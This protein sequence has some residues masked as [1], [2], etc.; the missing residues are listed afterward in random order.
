MLT[1]TNA[2]VAVVAVFATAMT[3][4]TFAKASV[5]I[6]GAILTPGRRTVC[7]ALRVM[8][9]GE[10][11]TFGKYHRV[12]SRDR[13]SPWRVSEIL[14][15]LL[16][17]TFGVSEMPL[18]L[19][20][21]ETLERR[22]GQAI[23]YKGVFR[24]GVRSTAKRVVKSLGIRWACMALL[25]KVPW[26]QREWALPF[27]IVPVLSPKTSERLHKRHRTSIDWTRFMIGRVRRWQPTRE[28]VVVGDGAYAATPLVQFCQRQQVRVTLITRLRFDACLYDEPSLQP[29]GK[30]GPKPK[31]GARLPAMKAVLA[32]PLTPWRVQ[33]VPWYDATQRTLHTLSGTAIWHPDGQP[34]VR[35]RWVLLNDPH[36]KHFTPVLLLC[37]DPH[38]GYSQIIAWFVNRWNIEVTFEES[39]AHLGI[40]SQRQ[41]SDRAIERSTPCL[42]GLF[43]LVVVMAQR[44]FPSHLP[45]RTNAWYQKTS[46]AYSDVLA[47]VRNHLWHH[48]QFPVSPVSPDSPLF[49]L[50][51]LDHL[52]S[53]AAYA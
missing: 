39:R 11:E 48:F 36:D 53:L 23:K 29:K 43:S 16:I 52:Q 24:D 27:M 19:L 15:Q 32:D 14:L 20:I 44:L 38:P 46:A 28:L 33:P 45:L 4:P 18:V 31:Q 7:A 47:A 49:P 42:F 22:Q 3:A 10:L 8:G 51:L 13:W 34:L 40:E 1:P 25:V 5:L 2:I 21:D 30:R 26:G 12:L 37:S 35:I 9:L 6:Y 17:D 50:A 41:W